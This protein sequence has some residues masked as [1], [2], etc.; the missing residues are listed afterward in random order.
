MIRSSLVLIAV[1]CLTRASAQNLYFPAS[2]Y[3]DSASL[4]NSLPS[5]AQKLLPQYHEPNKVLYYDNLF[6][7]Q[8]SAG[9]YANGLANLDTAA[10]LVVQ[11]PIESVGFCFFYKIFYRAKLQYDSD[12]SRPFPEVYRQSFTRY[13]SQVPPLST[14][15][16]IS[17]VLSDPAL[18]RPT[19]SAALEKQKANTKDSISVRDAVALCRAWLSVK[20]HKN[21]E[22]ARELVGQFEKKDYISDDSVLVRMP[23]G[24]NIALCI[25][26]RKDAST[27]LPVVL[28]YSI[29][30]GSEHA[31]AREAATHGYVGIIANTR[32]K[33][34]SPDETAPFEHDAKDAYALIDWI[35]KQ[36][37]CNGK[38]GMYGGS[39]LGFAQWSATKYLHPALKT[40]VPQVAVGIG[41]DYPMQNGVFMSYMLHWIHYVVNN[42]YTDHADF[43]NWKRWDSVNTA[44]YKSGRPFRGL[45]SIDGRPNAIFQR[46]L[47]HP[48]YDSYW[49]NMTPQKNEFAK[50][51]IPVLT[52]SGYWDADQLGAMYYFKQHYQWNK[53]A[54]HYLLIGPYNHGG[55]QGFP[56]K[57]LNGYT[58]DSAANIPIQ[59][60]VFSWFDHILK[61]SA[62][63]AILANKVNFEVM[64]ANKW[65]H[66]SSFS[67]MSNDSLTF[68]L[69]NNKS[70]NYP[71]LP[72]RPPTAGFITQ[73][74]DFKER[75]IDT[76]KDDNGELFDS[77]LDEKK[78]LVFTSAPLQQVTTVS[79]SIRIALKLLTNKKD[80]DIIIRLYEQTPNGKYFFLNSQVQRASYSKDRTKRQLL[81]PGKIETVNLNNNFLTSIQLAEGSRLV[82]TIGINK[83]PDWQLN[84]GSG[85]D[86]SHETIEDAAVPM[87]IKWYNSSCV[88]FPIL[89]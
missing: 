38:I 27:P 24:G 2:A 22:T 66:V 25:V 86:V 15:A 33:R 89:R 36:P 50:I 42:K 73:V 55:A 35:S 23:D 53:H 7:L 70:N 69:G 17:W 49:Q 31:D 41:V 13:Y 82:L 19:L 75:T 46:W 29:Y 65:E 37:W 59:K 48:S 8:L 43:E 14:N 85:K 61:D 20:M 63:P 5:L 83:S 47:D 28:M 21:A 71:L 30:P 16:V 10:R 44:W 76:S 87:Q 72:K 34:L 45:D 56:Q 18:F 9:D 84:Y 60:I 64:G 32:G 79:G 51:N 12:S 52:I 58:L 6:R 40:I 74:V 68:Y 1:C 88:T 78:N 62:L 54:D 11:D 77:V 57:V 67:E 26:R 39:Y 80:A 3:A 4:Q 81:Q